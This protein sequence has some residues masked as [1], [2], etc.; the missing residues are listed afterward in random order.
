MN[1][2]NTTER[3]GALS[4]GLHWLVLV[5]LIGVYAC[6]ELRGLLPK[7]SDPR[8]AMKT[9]HFM[10]GLAVLALVFARLAVRAIG[11]TPH[12]RPLPPAWQRALAALMHLALYVFM[13]AMPV[14]GWL[15]LSAAG[16]PIPFFGLT[17]PALVVPDKVLATSLKE[18]H[19]T[20][21]TLGYYLIGLHAVASL[22][23]HYIARDNTLRRMLPQRG[24]PSLPW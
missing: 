15:T 3:Y 14:L 21:G 24:H 19:E 5:L 10:L 8:E 16:K 13:I 22:F 2:R 9:W 7:G 17:L 23:H 6:I 12:I 1:F 20:I 4:I 11:P 18:V